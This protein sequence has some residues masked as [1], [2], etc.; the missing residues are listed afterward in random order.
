MKNIK[1]IELGFRFQDVISEGICEIIGRRIDEVERRVGLSDAQGRDSW[2]YQAGEG[3]YNDFRSEKFEYDFSWEALREEWIQERN[4]AIERKERE[5][6]FSEGQTEL[7]PQPQDFFDYWSDYNPKVSEDLLFLFTT[8]HLFIH[9]I[10]SPKVVT[11][12]ESL[13][14]VE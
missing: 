12:E 7:V 11:L 1:N 4:E 3:W 14:W 13:I 8:L 10:N 6:I 9:S 5:R 2:E